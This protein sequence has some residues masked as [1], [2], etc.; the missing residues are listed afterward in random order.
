LVQNFL[1]NIWKILIFLVKVRSGYL[2]IIK[3][4]KHIEKRLGSNNEILMFEDSNVSVILIILR[5][6]HSNGPVVK[7]LY[8]AYS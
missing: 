2:T 6:S 4:K 8:Q 7:D 5:N 3:K 1:E